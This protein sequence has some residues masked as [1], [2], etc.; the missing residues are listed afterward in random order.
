MNLN[1]FNQ[2]SDANSYYAD[3]SDGYGRSSYASGFDSAISPLSNT[4]VETRAKIVTRVYANL[5]G[6]VVAF[7][8]IVALIFAA[9]GPVAI[10]T[11]VQH[12]VKLV[13]F[14]LL[15]LCIGG[16]FI[17]NAILK[18][19]PSRVGQYFLLGFYVLMYVGIF[20]P[21]LAFAVLMVGSAQL[22]WQATGLTIALFAALSSAVF[23]TRKDFS[24][25]RAFL[26]Y[27]GIASLIVIVAALITGFSLGTWFSVA[28][29][30]LA[31]G[32]I[33]FETSDVML[34]TPEGAEVVA[35]VELFASVMM[36]FYYVLRLLMAFNRD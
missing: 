35:A 15:A 30:F 34:R 3:Q 9:V 12:N 27:A 13:S 24:F 14:G 28:M 18:A 36:L 31:C 33:L 19:N 25:M 29:I 7:A 8:A 20:L 2:R 23:M 11:F 22:I 6:A 5:T 16:P 21:V 17:G 4:S 1:N 26:F 10:A 32:Y